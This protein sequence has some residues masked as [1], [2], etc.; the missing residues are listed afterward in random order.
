VTLC[1]Q[2]HGDRDCVAQHMRYERCAEGLAEGHA[3]PREVGA[4]EDE[5]AQTVPKK[6]STPKMA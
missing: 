2:A 4:R 6:A 3:A 5:K 1:Q